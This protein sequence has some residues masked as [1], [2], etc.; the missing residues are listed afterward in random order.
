[1]GPLFFRRTPLSRQTGQTFYA[2]DR[3]LNREIEQAIDGLRPVA[4]A[5]RETRP[6][7]F[8][9]R[10]AFFVRQGDFRQA[11]RAFQRVVTLQPKNVTPRLRLFNALLHLGDVEQAEGVLTDIK[12]MKRSSEQVARLQAQ[13]DA[14][15]A[16]LRRLGFRRRGLGTRNL[17]AMPGNEGMKKKEIKPP[18]PSSPKGAGWKLQ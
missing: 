17:P 1:M 9:L 2:E 18:A 5:K 7:F 3:V 16:Q 8:M 15:R 4:L 10:G 6:A 11:K 13:L 12:R 14:R